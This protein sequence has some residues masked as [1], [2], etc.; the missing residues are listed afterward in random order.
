M[1]N[2]LAPR[3]FK[4]VNP[5]HPPPQPLKGTELPKE[6]IPTDG[7]GKVRIRTDKDAACDVTVD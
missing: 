2:K 6:N 4:C 1:S 5:P 3:V 7:D